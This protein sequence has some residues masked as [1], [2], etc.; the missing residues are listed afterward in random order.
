MDVVGQDNCAVK[1]VSK[2][3]LASGS[4]TRTDGQGGHVLAQEQV[5]HQQQQEGPCLNKNANHS[6]M[7]YSTE[8]LKRNPAE[9]SLIA[10]HCPQLPDLAL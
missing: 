5:W 2:G 3:H 10:P 8:V 9:E 6:E 1:Q 7:I 4:P